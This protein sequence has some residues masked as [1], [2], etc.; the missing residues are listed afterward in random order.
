MLYLPVGAV[1]VAFAACFGF[2][3][4]LE[5]GRPDQNQDE[6]TRLC[7]SGD[8]QLSRDRECSYFLLPLPPPRRL[9]PSITSTFIRRSSRQ[10]HKHAREINRSSR[11]FPIFRRT[12]ATFPP[13]RILPISRDILQ[14]CL[15]FLWQISVRFENCPFIFLFLFSVAF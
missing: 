3:Y 9:V 11:Y 13:R 7:A 6:N 1:A 4:G 5:R 2:L 15:I 10:G 12:R 8:S 14:F